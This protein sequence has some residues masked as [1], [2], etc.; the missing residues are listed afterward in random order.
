MLMLTGLA[1][2]AMACLLERGG[3]FLYF[4]YTLL[5][6]FAGLSA[7]LFI[8]WGVLRFRN[9]QRFGAI[10]SFLLSAI[11]L[12]LGWTIEGAVTSPRKQFYL[13]ADR[14]KPGDS[15][16]SVEDSLSHYRHWSTQEG[17]ITFQFVSP[18][19]A[20]VLIV[21]YDPKTLRVLD[22]NLSLD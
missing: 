10:V 15:L 4:S 1:V 11:F 18:G 9:R 6:T 17:H 7:G 5:K 12:I 3:F 16:N 19:T 21:H 13:L 14:V 2:L 8:W 22:T 20:D